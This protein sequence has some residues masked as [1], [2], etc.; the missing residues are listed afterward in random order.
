MWE[1]TLGLEVFYEE[2]VW[3]KA[4]WACTWGRE[5]YANKE[6]VWDNVVVGNVKGGLLLI[7]HF[8][9]VMGEWE[10]LD[11]F[12]ALIMSNVW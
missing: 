2:N 6:L 4:G 7:R 11:V 12:E 8:H 1:W 10:L 9:P 3:L 5:V